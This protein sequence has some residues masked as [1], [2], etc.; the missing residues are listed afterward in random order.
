M[1]RRG[2]SSLFFPIFATLLVL[3]PGCREKQ[4]YPGAEQ[5]RQNLVS[6]I[7]PGGDVS[8]EN[9]PDPR[10]L[11]M[12]HTSRGTTAISGLKNGE[13]ISVRQIPGFVYVTEDGHIRVV[14]PSVRS[15]RVV[16]RKKRSVMAGLVME[17][18]VPGEIKPVRKDLLPEL[19]A[20]WDETDEVVREAVQADP[21][22]A[23]EFYH[24][25][26]MVP[27]GSSGRWSVWIHTV[28]SYLGGAHPVDTRSLYA[29]DLESGRV[30]DTEALFEG[31]DLAREILGDRYDDACV[32]KMSGVAPVE[33]IGGE[34]LWVA[35]LTADYG[36]CEGRWSIK[37]VSGPSAGDSRHKP[38]LKLE[39][40]RLLTPDGDLIN[41]GV[42]D[43]RDSSDGSMVVFELG[44]GTRD[45]IDYPWSESERRHDRTREVRFHISGMERPAVISRLPEIHSVQFPGHFENSSEILRTL[46]EIKSG[47]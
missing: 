44:L 2:P 30:V 41:R 3:A 33:G 7:Q 11:A 20:G 12:I 22:M 47:N 1:R 43:F 46:N 13:A 31:R 16:T 5:I 8:P 15:C 32:R 28:D 23:N 27:A 38:V 36:V 29:V 14:K 26:G 35:L 45:R 24:A 19:T 42:V 37:A 34:P 17:E 40:G 25:E 39:E 18:Y 6:Q 4:P 21:D 10:L 9:A